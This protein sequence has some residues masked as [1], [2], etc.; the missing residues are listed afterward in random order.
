MP[1]I[2]CLFA[3]YCLLVRMLTEACQE[4]LWYGDMMIENYEISVLKQ[5]DAVVDLR[6]STSCRNGHVTF[7]QDAVARFAFA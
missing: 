4:R 5:F 3:V 2:D 6:R 7:G 1:L